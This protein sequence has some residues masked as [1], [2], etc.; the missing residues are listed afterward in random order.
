VHT[1]CDSTTMDHS[2]VRELIFGR[3]RNPVFLS[4][5]TVSSAL[6]FGPYATIMPIILTLTL[7]L[8]Y[9]RFIFRS[10]HSCRVLQ[11]YLLCALAVGASF[12]RFRASLSALS[13]PAESIAAL[14]VS[15][16]IL[17]C[18]TL[19]AL[20]VDTKFCTRFNSSWAQ[21]TLFPALWATLWCTISYFSPVGHLS[22]W[23][24][25]DHSD[26]YNW[27]VPIAG[28]ASKDWIIGAW[29]VV[30]SQFIGAWYMGRQDEDI[31]P[32][33]NQPR[34]QQFHFQVGILALCLTFATIPSFLIPQFPLP[35]SD[36]NVSTALTVGCVLPPFQRYKH[37]VLTLDDFIKES[38]KIR[39][40]ARVILWPE[41]AVIFNNASE[42]DEGLEL[43]RKRLPGTHIG[44]SFEETMDDP[45]DST[46]KTSIRRT[47]LAVVSQGSS[48]P[49]IYY[50]RHLVPCE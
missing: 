46:G 31:L 45:R 2:D 4:I 29:A 13:T 49:H 39:S 23:S 11:A 7:L 17:S 33:D 34:R 5:L 20:Y 40:S 6:A 38:E 27:I 19:L 14:F 15:A 3:Y 8:V 50:K 41:G 48:E 16:L 44:V 12:S 25:A 28:P 32:Q 26:A 42:R 10:A 22:T 35:V 18:L 43:V 1:P 24:A 9:S 30:M 37:H 47:G 21:I 36:I